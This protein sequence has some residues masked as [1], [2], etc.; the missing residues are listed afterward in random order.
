LHPLLEEVVSGIKQF[1]LILQGM[2][3]AQDILL[4][5]LPKS[6]MRQVQVGLQL[7]AQV[8]KMDI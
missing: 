6:I 8:V 1:Q 3:I 2:Y 5:A 4:A 7:P